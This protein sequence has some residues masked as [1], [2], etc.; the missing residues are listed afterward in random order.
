MSLILT[1]LGFAVICVGVLGL[2]S[3]RRLR[4][5]SV[6]GQTRSRFRSA[7]MMRILVGAGLIA[8]APSSRFPDTVTV[9]GVAALLLAIG[10]YR[11]GM[12]RFESV[13]YFWSNRPPVTLRAVSMVAVA[14]GLFLVYAPA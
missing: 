2:L 3:P 1:V 4:E 11:L 10:L 13:S 14:F 9:L 5:L 6:S 12:R 7:V 8:A